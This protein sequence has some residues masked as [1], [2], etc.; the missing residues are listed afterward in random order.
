MSKLFF[1]IFIF[2]ILFF[3]SHSVNDL[4]WNKLYRLC[5]FTSASALGNSPALHMYC[6]HSWSLAVY[7][8][9]SVSVSV[10]VQSV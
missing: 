5:F 6:M 1:I 10:C 4:C 3:I 2:L 8:C 9:V 7:V